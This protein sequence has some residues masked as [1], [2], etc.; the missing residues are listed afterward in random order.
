MDTLRVGE[1]TLMGRLT[2]SGRVRLYKLAG[3]GGTEDDGQVTETFLNRKRNARFS[4]DRVS[5]LT[6]AT[7]AAVAATAAATAAATTQVSIHGVGVSKRL[8]PA[9]SLW[10]THG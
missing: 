8:S 3:L 5:L 2:L 4:A 6:A 7:A 1:L 10:K 9:S